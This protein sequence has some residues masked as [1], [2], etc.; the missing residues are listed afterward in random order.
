MEKKTINDLDYIDAAFLA[1][2]QSTKYVASTLFDKL[3]IPS[4]TIPKE[5]IKRI[6]ED[7]ELLEQQLLANEPLIKTTVEQPYWSKGQSQ[8]DFDEVS[9]EVYGS[10]CLADDRHLLDII[11]AHGSMINNADHYTLR[12][13][14][15]LCNLKV[16]WENYPDQSEIDEKLS[17]KGCYFHVTFKKLFEASN[18]TNV[19]PNRESV[20]KRL[21]RLSMMQLFLRFHKQG[22]EV[23]NRSAKVSIVGRDF[24]ALQDPTQ[25]RNK[26]SITANTVTD[27]I[28]NVSS[29]YVKTLDNDGQIS[30][31]RFLNN[32]T[33]LNG[34]NGV[35][36]FLKYIDSHKRSFI[37]DKYLSELVEDYYSGKMS[38]FGMNKNFKIKQTINILSTMQDELIQHFNL[39]LKKEIRM[40]KED[41]RLLYLPALEGRNL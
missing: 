13:A 26:K 6:A 12:Q 34:K 17:N 22:Q 9:I 32:Y 27:L 37:H 7:R 25:I 40:K 15:E 16:N 41:W 19:K 36:D 3:F 5:L 24:H 28:V 23:P 39:V 38:L 4:K 1:D 30:R 10:I 2:Y 20:L 14:G 11:I 35:V 29:F 8:R 18:L 33:S 31:K 21:H